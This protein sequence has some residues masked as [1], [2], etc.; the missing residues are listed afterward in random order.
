MKK[1]IITL[2]IITFLAASYFGYV[3]V[4]DLIGVEKKVQ[5]VEKVEDNENKVSDPVSTSGLAIDEQQTQ[6]D[7]KLNPFGENI[8][9]MEL[10]DR[11]IQKYIHGMSHQKVIANE[12]W[13]Y[14]EIRPGRITWL[15]EALNKSTEL[16]QK[17]TYERI[18]TKWNDGDFTS[19]DKDHNDI[20]NLQG[21]N[22]G[23]ATG[24][25]TAEEEEAYKK[26][27]LDPS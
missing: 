15:L 17:D 11:D 24:I 22:I 27:V 16:N 4:T 21:G 12:M 19:V 20:W 8:Q 18:L 14:Y 23:K 2:S 13:G 9:A 3:I 5:E 1:I 26:S 10:T 25:K 6:E 7:G